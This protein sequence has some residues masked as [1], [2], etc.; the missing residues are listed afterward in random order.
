MENCKICSSN[1]SFIGEAPIRSKYLIRYFM[2]NDCGFIQTENPYWLGES[3]EESIAFSDVGYIERNLQTSRTTALVINY[4]FDKSKLF[5]DFAGGYGLFTRIM[6]DQGFQ[7]YSQDSYTKNLFSQY[8]NVDLKDAEEKKIQLISAFEVF[9]H[10]ENPLAEVNKLFRISDSLL[11][12]TTLIPANTDILKTNWHYLTPETG[13]HIAFY[14]RK[15]F[16]FI[17]SKY[18]FRYYNHGVYH[19]LTKKRIVPLLFK[20]ICSPKTQFLL[21]LFVNNPKSLLQKDYQ[22]ILKSKA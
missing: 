6:R 10:L 19:L 5:L 11:L 3:Y 9:E 16:E 14:T 12:T 4:F 18:G 22:E 1:S 2:C 20:L 8:F 13:Q 7:F 17:A 15:S 21:K